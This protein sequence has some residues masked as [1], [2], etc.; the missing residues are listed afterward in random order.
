MSLLSLITIY[1]I[2]LIFWL[3]IVQWGGAEWLEGT[4]ISG[5]LVHI[6]AQRWSAQGIKLFGYGII[7]VSTL[8]FILG[9]FYPDFRFF[10]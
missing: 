7:I 4:F 10:F 6:F 2:N 9:I 3:W 5:F 1:L 8:L